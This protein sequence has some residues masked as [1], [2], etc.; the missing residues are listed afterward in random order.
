MAC[1]RLAVCVST[2]CLAIVILR[3]MSA[4]AYA[5]PT[6][7]PGEII[8]EKLFSSITFPLVSNFFMGGKGSPR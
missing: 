7:I 2:P 4:V 6:L 5:L 3:I 1:V 8:F